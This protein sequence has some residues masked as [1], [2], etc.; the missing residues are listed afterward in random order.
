MIEI[1][2]ALLMTLNGNIVE[3]TYKEKLSQCMKSK[4][5]AEKEVNPERVRFSCKQVEA[6]TEIYMVSKKILKIIS[7]VR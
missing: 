3:H 6:K 7:I 1:V 4:R 5:I 2:F